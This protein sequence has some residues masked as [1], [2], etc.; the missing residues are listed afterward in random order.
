M[1]RS[2]RDHIWSIRL[3]S[4]WMIYC[5]TVHSERLNSSLSRPALSRRKRER[6][7]QIMPRGSMHCACSR[8]GGVYQ[9]GKP[10]CP[11]ICFPARGACVAV[12]RLWSVSD[13]HLF[14]M[15][16]RYELVVQARAVS[17]RGCMPRHCQAIGGTDQAAGIARTDRGDR[18]R[19][20]GNAGRGLP[21]GG[22]GTDP[23]LYRRSRDCRCRGLG[24][25]PERHG[26]K[27]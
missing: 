6:N 12:G 8:T 1:A 19:I 9:R 10:I 2:Y 21:D 24:L 25:S 22:S 5:H 15:G 16:G 14:S 27:W 7:A 4:K 20:D 3:P 26:T 11:T 23:G 18:N 13:C 17:G